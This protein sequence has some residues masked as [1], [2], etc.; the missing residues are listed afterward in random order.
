LGAGVA[1]AAGWITEVQFL[2]RVG[3]FFFTT[4]SRLALGPTHPPNP[5]VLGVSFPGGKAAGA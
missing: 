5:W 2:V 1:Q 3:I 4:M